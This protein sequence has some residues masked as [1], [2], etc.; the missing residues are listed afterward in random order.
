VAVAENVDRYWVSLSEDEQIPPVFTGAHRFVSLKFAEDL[1]KLVYSVNVENI[2]NVTGIYV[3]HGNKNN[4]TI[5]LDLLKEAKELTSD[6]PKLVNI[7][8]EG[9]ISGTVAVGGLTADDLRG[10]L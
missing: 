6:D 8:R 5:V 2:N 9:K 1:T 3:Y 10:Q 4:G 7:S